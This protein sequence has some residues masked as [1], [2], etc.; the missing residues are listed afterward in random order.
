MR[1]SSLSNI[2]KLSLLVGANAQVEK[3]SGTL[4]PVVS[5][6]D[7]L[8]TAYDTNFPNVYRDNGGG[9]KVNGLNLVVFADTSVT[10]GGRN[11]ELVYFVSNSVAVLDYVNFPSLQKKNYG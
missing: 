9:G 2:V 5:S 3:R 7:L 11:G 4:P 1:I 10:N 6:V 8:G